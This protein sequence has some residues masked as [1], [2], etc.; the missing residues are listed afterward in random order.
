MGVLDYGAV[1]D[2]YAGR[3]LVVRVDAGDVVS[4]SGYE[5]TDSINVSVGFGCRLGK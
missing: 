5:A 1:I 4:F 2:S 3:R